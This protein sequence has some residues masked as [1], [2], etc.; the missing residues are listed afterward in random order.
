M[1]QD[2]ESMYDALIKLSQGLHE[3]EAKGVELPPALDQAW[4]EITAWLET[5]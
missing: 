2:E 5:K 4:Q 1:I 3:L